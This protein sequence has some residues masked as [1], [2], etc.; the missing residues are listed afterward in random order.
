MNRDEGSSGRA[1]EAFADPDVN[2]RQH[3]APVFSSASGGRRSYLE[4]IGRPQFAI[5]TQP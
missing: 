2:F 1:P 5:W 4:M 3:S